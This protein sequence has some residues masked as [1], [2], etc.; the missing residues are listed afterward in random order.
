MSIGLATKGKICKRVDVVVT[1][2]DIGCV[3][4]DVEINATEKI[5]VVIC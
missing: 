4:I 3:N 1:Y 5:N 2:V